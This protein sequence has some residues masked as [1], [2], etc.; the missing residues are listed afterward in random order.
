MWRKRLRW[1]VSFFAV[2][3]V[4]GGVFGSL[5]VMADDYEEP[6][7][8]QPILPKQTLVIISAQGR[9]VFSVELATT[10]RQQQV[11]E[12]FRKS[13]PE[14][15]GMLFLWSK[16]Q[17]SDMWMRNTLIPLDIVFIGPDRRIQAIAENTVPQSLAHISSHGPVIA[18]LELA[19]GITAKLGIVVGDKVESVSLTPKKTKRINEKSFK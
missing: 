12:M 9:H 13:V 1:G 18:T 14:N 5:P 15:G 19:G 4:V 11:G 6:T 16:P 10:P 7:H 2:G 17:Q 3:L 8:A